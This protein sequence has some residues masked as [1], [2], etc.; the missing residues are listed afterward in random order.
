METR[1]QTHT[2][3]NIHTHSC[4][5]LLCVCVWM[6]YTQAQTHSYT[7]THTHRRKHTHTHTLI[8]TQTHTHPHAHAHT[9]FSLMTSSP[10]HTPLFIAATPINLIV[11]FNPSLILFHCSRWIQLLQTGQTAHNADSRYSCYRTA[12]FALKTRAIPAPGTPA[13]SWLGLQPGQT[14]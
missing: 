5:D 8:H 2:G 14:R 3:A 13:Y 11:N 10:C 4:T 6:R 12:P 1:R 7:H 9:G